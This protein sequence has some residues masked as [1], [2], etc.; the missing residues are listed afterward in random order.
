MKRLDDIAGVGLDL[1]STRIKAG[2]LDGRGRLAS[3]RAVDAPALHG[4]G[5]IREGD[6]EA[7]AEAAFGL[8]ASVAAD[9]APGTPLGIATQRSTFVIWERDSGRPS[10]PM[11]SWQDRRA[12]AWCARHRS[13]EPDVVRRTGLL[14]T[15]HYAGPK[16]AAMQADDPAL[17]DALRSGRQLFGTLESFLVWKWSRERVHETD[18]SV[19]ARTLMVNIGDGRWSDELLGHFA[20]PPAVLPA[21]VPTAGRSVELGVGLRL[22]ATV[23][24]QAAG[25]LAVLDAGS[26]CALVNL[27]TGAFVLRNTDDGAR[28]REGYL[29]APILGGP[30][31]TRFTIEGTI[32][33]AGPALDRFGNGPTALPDVDPSPAAFAIPDLAGLGSPYWR[34]GIGLT[35]S[36]GARA[37]DAA[38]RR[39]AVLEGLLF[40][41]AQILDELFEIAPPDRLLLAGGVAREPAVP[42]GLATLLR[43]PVDVL[44]ERE[45]G[46]TG[47]ARLAAGLGPFARGTTRS[48]EP[49][50]GAYLSSK[51]PKW[52]SWLESVLSG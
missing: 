2:L 26:R 5:G 25:A 24:D 34:P 49:G 37:L 51:L 44:V 14:L 6:A 50:G 4:D 17:R 31:A 10:R 20:V 46:L 33:G 15:A 7:Y 36:A 3:V 32:N 8:L 52:S 48:V 12:A 42:A 30:E 43:R 27:G 28:R 18:L 21:I 19:A 9:V 39:R 13:L 23:A 47:A 1:G 41:I 45:S 16:L 35:L 11:V 38:G 29:T 22:A 40:R